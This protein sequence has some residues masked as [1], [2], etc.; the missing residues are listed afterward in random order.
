MVGVYVR[1]RASVTVRFMVRFNVENWVT[2]MVSAKDSVL[3]P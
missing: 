2:V 1:V 3:L